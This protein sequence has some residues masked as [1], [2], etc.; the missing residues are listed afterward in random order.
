MYV[1]SSDYT[2][3]CR[4]ISGSREG[5]GLMWNQKCVCIEWCPIQMYNIYKIDY[6]CNWY[7]K[8]IFPQIYPLRINDTIIYVCMY[9]HMY[10][11][12]RCNPNEIKIQW[13]RIFYNT[14]LI[15][16]WFICLIYIFH[17]IINRKSFSRRLF[18]I[19]PDFPSF[20]AFLGSHLYS[21]DR[22]YI[23]I[24]ICIRTHAR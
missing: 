7:K 13:Q 6:T 5:T 23:Y 20:H 14:Y 10:N 8:C 17:Q 12:Y 24:C 3:V 22:I 1:L 15:Q 4:V 11:R 19:F 16:N 18:S 2:Y 9:I 21:T